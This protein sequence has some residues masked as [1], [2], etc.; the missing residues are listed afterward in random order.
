[1][2]E[3]IVT[4][5]LFCGMLV[6]LSL[7][8]FSCKSKEKN[9]NKNI[10]SVTPSENSFVFEQIEVPESSKNVIS[11]RYNGE[12]IA[13]NGYDPYNMGGQAMLNFVD[14]KTC[15]TS[16][17]SVDSDLSGFS[18][19]LADEKYIYIEHDT[20]NQSV[21]VIEKLDRK[22]GEIIISKEIDYF[23]NAADMFFDDNGNICLLTDRYTE[24]KNVAQVHIYSRDLELIDAVDLKING[25]TPLNITEYDGSYFL[26]SQS[27]NSI[28]KIYNLKKDFSSG[29]GTEI[30]DAAELFCDSVISSDGDLLVLTADGK[31]EKLYIDIIDTENGK[32]KEMIEL[33]DIPYWNICGSYDNYDFIYS[34]IDGVYGYIIDNDTSEKIISSDDTDMTDFKSY[35]LSQDELSFINYELYNPLNTIY[36]SDLNGNIID[37]YT[38]DLPDEEWFCDYCI[39]GNGRLGYVSGNN[40]TGT[41]KYYC[42]DESGERKEVKIEN[43][44]SYNLITADQSGN[45]CLA[46]TDS[47]NDSFHLIIIDSQLNIIKDLKLNAEEI[48]GLCYGKDGNIYVSEMLDGKNIISLIDCG[49][50]EKIKD[51]QADDYFPGQ[52]EGKIIN[53]SDDY[54]FYYFDMTSV[55]GYLSQTG[56]FK[57]IL[58]TDIFENNILDLYF[59]NINTMVCIGQ[60]LTSSEETEINHIYLLMKSDKAISKKKEIRAALFG[61]ADDDIRLMIKKYNKTSTEYYID[62]VDYDFS[63]LSGFNADISNGNI[64]DI[65]ITSSYS[66][67]TSWIR[68]DLTEDL[69]EYFKNDNDISL[70]QYSQNIVSSCESD[71]KINFIYPSYKINGLIGKSSDV[72]DGTGWTVDEFIS[73]M[74]ADQKADFCNISPEELLEKIVMSNLYGFTDFEK[75]ECCFDNPSFAAYLDYFKKISDNTDEKND[76]PFRNNKTTLDFIDMGGF[77][78]FNL[79]EKGEIG[80]ISSLKGMPGIYESSVT[81]EPTFM[82]GICKKSELKSQSWEFIK[83]FLTDEYQDSVTESQKFFPVKSS[84]YD[85]LKQKQTAADSVNYYYYGDEEIQIYGID[86]ETLER[87]ADIVNSAKRIKTDD[88]EINK[89][90]SEEINEFFYGSKESSEVSKNLQRRISVYLSEKS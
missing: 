23:D 54:D 59:D 38:I 32:Q 75:N 22:T 18:H 20:E 31:N 76:Y 63:D 8:L 84:S 46:V 2:K 12:K 82:M 51:I 26:L 77:K 43:Y 9:Q 55:Y 27:T 10:I 64:P 6:L 42:I 81:I 5:S 28:I 88:E 52:S 89:I 1:M 74:E 66:D 16:N 44:A 49:T 15:Q 17:I 56:K 70:D 50:G 61:Q 36:L 68:N 87:I 78:D 30:S 71:G 69:N 21:F 13:F 37:K 65:L 39:T 73:C 34:D 57:E 72:T 41:I 67:M 62:A 48:T 33:D 25:Q 29:F 4:R 47:Q 79:M 80:E 35:C 83:S 14:L 45:V 11:V 60:D 53:G 58:D 86:D 90:I 85:L 7:G 3:K 19:C 40:Q 24:N